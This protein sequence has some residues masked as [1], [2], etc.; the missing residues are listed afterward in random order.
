M[1]KTSQLC[2]DCVHAENTRYGADRYNIHISIYCVESN[3]TCINTKKGESV[4]PMS[5]GL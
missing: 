5:G 1:P 3:T 2:G 4:L